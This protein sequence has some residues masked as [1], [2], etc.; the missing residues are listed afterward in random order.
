MGK[1]NRSK[2][3]IWG[4]VL[5]ILVCLF[6]A[7][8]GDTDTVSN[9]VD[10]INILTDYN[11]PDVGD[12]INA[13][14]LDKY[15]FVEPLKTALQEIGN[16]EIKRVK[17]ESKS[18]YASSIRL[19]VTMPDETAIMVDMVKHDRNG[20]WEIRRVTDADNK[21]VYYGPK[22]T[23]S[24]LLEEN[25]YSFDT[26]EIIQSAASQEELDEY[27]NNLHEELEANRKEYEAEQAQ[28]G[29]C[30][31]NDSIKVKFKEVREDTSVFAGTV[32]K[33]VVFE[34]QNKTNDAITIIFNS[35]ALDGTEVMV[36]SMFNQS[37]SGNAT[38]QITLFADNDLVEVGKKYNRV[39]G[40]FSGLDA[41]N[42][43]K[44]SL[45]GSFTDVPL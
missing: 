32:G 28:K 18:E 43:H 24:G 42:Q 44:D 3:I 5:F 41:N 8:N 15:D 7:G 30:Y 27:Y 9:D 25:V 13:D 33:E 31:E 36:G 12:H 20:D 4:V 39:S 34:V 1:P 40:S 21:K 16:I 35:C 29:L 11:T 38:G 22:T 14:K 45:S 19:K 37:I 10:K 17:I 26:G 23:V 6:A 2:V